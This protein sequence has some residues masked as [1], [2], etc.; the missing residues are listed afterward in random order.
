VLR[1]VTTWPRNAAHDHVGMTHLSTPKAKDQL[2]ATP[3][4][5]LNPDVPKSEIRAVEAKHDRAND[6]M[7]ELLKG[8]V[9]KPV[10]RRA[11]E[12]PS[13]GKH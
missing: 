9:R 7:V 6:L 5:D 3:S 1:G 2:S 12:K 4:P 8:A 10:K 13:A 11:P